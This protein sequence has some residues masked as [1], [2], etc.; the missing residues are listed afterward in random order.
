MIKDRRGIQQETG[1][2]MAIYRVSDHRLLQESLDHAISDKKPPALALA[3]ANGA[4]KKLKCFHSLLLVSL[5]S[6][7]QNSFLASS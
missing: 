1:S 2:A 6:K 3:L 4:K 5:E 7:N